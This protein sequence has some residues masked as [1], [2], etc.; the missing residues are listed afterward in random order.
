MISL[1]T[2]LY[3]TWFNLTFINNHDKKLRI[4]NFF[5]RSY[6]YVSKMKSVLYHHP[7]IELRKSP[8]HGY[9]V[10]ATEDIPADTILEEVS[11]IA[12]PDNVA[13]DYVF[14]YP[15]GGTPLSETIGIRTEHALPLG[16]A[17]IY[18]HSDNANASWRTDTNT[19][20][21]VFFTLSDI[22]KN[23]EI[24]TYYGSDSYW[25]YHSHVNKQ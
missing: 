19:R 22:K 12:V 10:F 21:F 23:D 20:L 15:R 25:K 2:L 9:G 11:F 17:C 1:I 18:N 3:C 5:M 16:Y 13:R 6:Y 14:Q 8:I 4:F 24:R 7:H